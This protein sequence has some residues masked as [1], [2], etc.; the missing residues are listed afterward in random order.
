MDAVPPRGGRCDGTKHCHPSERCVRTYCRPRLGHRSTDVE[1]PENAD[2][3]ET[4]EVEAAQCR[5]NKDCRNYKHCVKGTCQY[6]R[7]QP[8]PA[9]VADDESG[10]DEPLELESRGMDCVSPEQCTG[11][12]WC[13]HGNCRDNPG[14]PSVNQHSRDIADQSDLDGSCQKD[15]DCRDG[16]CLEKVCVKAGKH[17]SLVLL[18]LFS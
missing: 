10:A 1:A 18:G 5:S 11:G 16:V 9:L 15:A 14:L 2:D 3:A 12:K 13:D 7:G 17:L 8:P 6:M 4:V